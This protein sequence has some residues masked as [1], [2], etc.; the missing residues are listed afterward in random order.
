MLQRPNI[1]G[2]IIAPTLGDARE[3][4]VIG[5]SGIRAHNPDVRWN[6]NEGALTWPNGS[7]AKIFGAYTPEDVERLRAGGNSEVDWYEEFAAWSKLDEAWDQARFGLRM[8]QHPKTIITTTPKPKDRLRW[9]LGYTNT[10]N[11]QRMGSPPAAVISRATTDDNPHLAE[12]V[13]R[14]LYARYEGTR[15][16][17]QEL[18]GEMLDDTPGALW[19]RD[20]LDL[21]RVYELPEMVRVVVGVD[22]A[23]TSN[24]GSDETGIIVVGMGTDGHGY[25]F[26]DRSVK[27]GF[28]RAAPEVV[29]AFEDFQGDRIVPEVNNGGDMVAS[30]LRAI[31]PNL[32]IVVV[33]ASRGKRVRAEPIAMLYQQGRIHHWGRDL[34]ELE[35]QMCN[36]LPVPGSTT[37]S[38]D[39]V[40][41]LVWA[42]TDLFPARMIETSALQLAQLDRVYG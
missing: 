34:V 26:A 39:R 41:A 25:V 36:F 14:G 3:A 16:G 29:R 27:L 8:G 28:D 2:R 42:L 30:T 38:P 18:A 6:S 19:T 35:D 12:G 10:E 24:A 23:V 7:R 4:C 17:R 9:I 5:P 21:Q 11:L 40:D 31:N 33:H 20:Q 37:K 32:P 22:P 13:R 1:R 15:E